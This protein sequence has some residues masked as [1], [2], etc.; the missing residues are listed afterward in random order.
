M[1]FACFCMFLTQVR[2]S[3]ESSQCFAVVASAAVGHWIWPRHA[4]CCD[5]L[6]YVFVEVH[7]FS[8]LRSGW[9]SSSRWR[10]HSQKKL[11]KDIWWKDPRDHWFFEQKGCQ[12]LWRS[13]IFFGCPHRQTQSELQNDTRRRRREGDERWLTN[14]RPRNGR[15]RRARAA[16]KGVGIRLE[17]FHLHL[18]K[19]VLMIFLGAF[20]RVRSFCNIF[21]EQER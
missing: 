16:K 11:R 14:K 18:L 12:N 5:R 19:L 7:F 15:P 17:V 8:P 21:L 6:G 4:V 20:F 10:W 9:G 2:R 13:F 1:I 3:E